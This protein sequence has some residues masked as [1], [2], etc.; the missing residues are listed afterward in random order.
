MSIE[1]WFF[2]SA[3]QMST[4]QANLER[5]AG[6]V[7]G[8]IT[9]PNAMDMYPGLK[10]IGHDLLTQCPVS[11]MLTHNQIHIHVLNLNIINTLNLCM[12]YIFLHRNCDTFIASHILI[13][14]QA[15]S[16]N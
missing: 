1:T 3:R 4:P 15:Y 7:E 14:V 12:S 13:Y 8:A 6:L 10:R 9:H 16:N 5:C 11:S 2:V